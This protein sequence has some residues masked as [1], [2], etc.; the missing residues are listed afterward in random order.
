MVPIKE[1][2]V[3]YRHM[4]RLC[5]ARVEIAVVLREE[6]HVVEDETLEVVLPER[7]GGAHVQ[8]HGT[9]EGSVAPILNNEDTV[10]HQLFLEK[11]VNVD[12]ECP[13]VL[14]PLSVGNNDGHRRDTAEDILA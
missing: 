9:V 3:C 7:L 10:V 11:G 6:V 5:G 8:Q 4:P 13:Q 2:I 12:E 14:F 1:A